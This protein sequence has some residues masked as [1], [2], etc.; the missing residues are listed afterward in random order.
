MRQELLPLRSELE[1]WRDEG[2]ILPLWWRDDDAVA[3]T[4]ALDRLLGLAREFGAPLHLAVIPDPAG[5]RLAG[6]LSETTD[7]RVLPHGW[8]HAN[9]APADQ[10][11]AEFGAHRALPVML[12]EIAEGWRRLQDLFGAQAL[13]LFTPPWNR[14]T[15]DVVE[16][17]AGMGLAGI[18]T[19]APRPQQFAAPGL[20]QVN[21]H[22]NPI[23]SRTRGLLDPALIAIR[24][25]AELADRRKGL[26]DNAEPYGLLTHHLVHDEA[27]WATVA[28][29]LEAFCESG[30]ARWK[31]PLDELGAAD[32]LR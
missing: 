24:V 13:P 26:A 21:T 23:D 30:V 27:I 32:W 6:R 4:P 25:A 8:R 31:G 29:L 3:P 10:K 2:R 5:P 17:L 7:V 14:L 16:A 20:L 1:R 22:L 12:D 18:S 28:D 9:H 11:K 19:Y 15:P